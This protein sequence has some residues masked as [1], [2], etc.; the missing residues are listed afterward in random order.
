VLP[1]EVHHVLA[2]RAEGVGGAVVQGDADLD[3][4]LAPV[5]ADDQLESV[6]EGPQSGLGQIGEV[7]GDG[8]G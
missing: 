3:M 4:V 2:Q 6:E 8:G 5:V 7:E 1:R